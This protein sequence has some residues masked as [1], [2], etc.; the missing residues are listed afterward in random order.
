MK[1]KIPRHPEGCCPY[2][3]QN[4]ECPVC[5]DPICDCGNPGWA[6]ICEELEQEEQDRLVISTEDQT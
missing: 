1:R 5:D 4:E 2:H 6:C 3:A